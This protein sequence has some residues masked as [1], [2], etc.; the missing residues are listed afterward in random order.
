MKIS[1]GKIITIYVTGLCCIFNAN[2]KSSNIAYTDKNVRITVISDKTLRLEYSPNG[3]FVDNK[4]FVAVEREYDEVDFSQKERKGWVEIKTAGLKLKYKKGSGRFTKDNLTIESLQKDFPMVWHPE[5]QQKENLKGTYRTL[6]AADGTFLVYGENANDTI[7][8][9]DGLLAR[10]GWTLIDDSNGLLFDNDPEW[11]WVEERKEQDV[12]DWYFMAYGTDYKAALKYYTLFAGKMPMIP[13]FALGYWWSRYW[14]YSDREL[15]DLVQRLHEYNFPLDVLV[16]DMDWHY[17]EQGKGGWTGWTWNRRLFPDPKKFLDYTEDKGLKVTLNLHPA[18]G[19]ASYEEQYKDVARDMGF[20]T[21]EGKTIPWISSD[22]PMVE[23]V[24][25]NILTPME[26]DG[27]DFWW[28]DWQ[29]G[30]YDSKIKK[31]SNTWWVSRIFYTQ[32]ENFTDKRPMIYHRWG[33]LGNH[34]YQVGFSGDTRISWKSLDFQ[35]YFN[36]TSSNVLFGYWS[37]DLGGH[38]GDSIDPELYV[39]WMQFGVYTPIMRTHSTKDSRLNKEPWFFNQE[40]CDALRQSVR[41]RYNLVPYIYTM[42][43]KAYDEAVSLCCP[44]Y[45]DY[46]KNEEAYTFKNEYMFGNNILVNPITAPMKG[47]Y[48]DVKTWLPEGQWYELSSG[49]MLEGGKVVERNFSIDEF[50]VYVKAGSIVPMLQEDVMNLQDYDKYAYILAVYPGGE[51]VSSF[52]LYEDAGDSK[53]YSEAYSNTLLT[54]E[55]MADKLVF[56]INKR[57]GSY[58]GMPSERKYVL[59]L[60]SSDVPSSVM[61]DGQPI[62]YTYS[63]DDFSVMIDLGKVSYSN[64]CRVEVTYDNNSK[65]NL[66][67]LVGASK[68]IARAIEGLKYRD[69]NICLFDELG[70]MGSL[71]EAVMYQPEELHRLT[72]EFWKSFNDLN[73]V[74][75]RQGLNEDNKNW[76]LKNIGL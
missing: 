14:S 48:S 41:Q 50:P 11:R 56:T 25:K 6:D 67:G 60:V 46:P 36:S 73:G 76:F 62:D 17:T 55:R 26:H 3:N 23:S 24:F 7:K 61:M 75:E 38:F 30:L 49:A 4:S 12:Q 34:R 22:K 44:M 39:R 59:K 53:D 40:I 31:L 15:R 19:V 57:T 71:S 32:M 51:G 29:Q 72:E 10:D 70:N 8:I 65:V 43:R 63:G 54:S 66:N 68:R 1:I 33:G 52:N 5:M 20:D 27:V 37:H 28:L 42:C 21:S 9:E 13:R 47:L 58:E 16:M 64:Q 35:P 45:Y 2:A 18:D 69:A 74:L